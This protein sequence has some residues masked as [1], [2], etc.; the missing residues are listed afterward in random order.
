MAPEAARVVKLK[1]T[2]SGGG[3]GGGLHMWREAVLFRLCCKIRR[4]A[5]RSGPRSHTW[6]VEAAA[7]EG[8]AA[9]AGQ[10]AVKAGGG[11]VGWGAAGA[12]RVG[13]GRVGQV[14]AE[15]EMEAE[16][17]V[18]RMG[19]EEAAEMVVEAERG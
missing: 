18:V 1:G 3:A 10:A 8:G 13:A 15:V 4:G 2:V 11:K 6:A 7:A 16:G 17:V 19:A 5:P 12:E 9:W 14:V